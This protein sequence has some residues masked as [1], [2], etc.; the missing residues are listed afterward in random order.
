M[1]NL[2]E[3]HWDSFNSEETQTRP[4]ALVWMCIAK[5]VELIHCLYCLDSLDEN[6]ICGHSGFSEM[7]RVMLKSR[8]GGCHT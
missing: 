8:L 5:E 4:S 1:K 7:G 2:Y 6:H 3:Y